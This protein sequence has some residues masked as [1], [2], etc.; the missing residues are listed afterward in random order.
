MTWATTVGV[1][2]G[3]RRETRWAM[4]WVMMWVTRMAG[5]MVDDGGVDGG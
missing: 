5:L 2:G 1:D 3:Q 4:M